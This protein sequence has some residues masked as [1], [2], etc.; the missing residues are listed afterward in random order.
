MTVEG[1]G[2]KARHELTAKRS[3]DRWNERR[4]GVAPRDGDD[5]RGAEKTRAAVVIQREVSH[6][7]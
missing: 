2:G 4:G 5:H 6:F 7:G 1:L 3:G